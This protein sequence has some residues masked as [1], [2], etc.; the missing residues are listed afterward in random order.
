MNKALDKIKD[1]YRLKTNEYGQKFSSL[2]GGFLA[3]HL[4]ILHHK[5]AVAAFNQKLE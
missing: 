2:R 1:K 3:I 4:I 5:V